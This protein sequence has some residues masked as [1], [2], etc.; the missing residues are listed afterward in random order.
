MA[1]GPE[2]PEE[3]VARAHP[4][5]TP[6]TKRLPSPSRGSPAGPR[7]PGGSRGAGPCPP[8][9]PPP[10]PLEA[11]APSSQRHAAHPPRIIAAVAAFPQNA[12]LLPLSSPSPHS[13]VGGGDI[14]N[15]AP[16]PP[17][18]SA[19][20]AAAW[21]RFPPT[22]PPCAQARGAAPRPASRCRCHTARASPALRRTGPRA[23]GAAGAARWSLTHPPSR[24]GSPPATPAPR[25]RG[26]RS[27]CRCGG[28][29]PRLRPELGRRQVK[30]GASTPLR[31]GGGGGGTASLSA[32]RRRP[33]AP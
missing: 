5:T 4:D 30:R 11:R 23:A 22:R 17:R 26:K 16:P 7:R 25:P 1:V 10:A 32:A 9:H 24:V 13:G 29:V 20:T 21:R 3:K 8:C 28:R 12:G 6:S 14:F 31:G 27:G 19:P 33:P 18:P 15:T 2:A